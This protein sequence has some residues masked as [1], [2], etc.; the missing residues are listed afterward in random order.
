MGDH[1]RKHL[2]AG[3]G[4]EGLGDRDARIDA[5]IV[6]QRGSQRCDG[7][8]FVD[9]AYFDEI[10]ADRGEL[11]RVRETIRIGHGGI[12][13]GAKF[14]VER[15]RQ[16]FQRVSASPGLDL[17]QADHVGIQSGQRR[18]QFIGLARQF[19]RVISS[20]RGGV[21]V[22]EKKILK[23]IGVWGRDAGIYGGC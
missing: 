1:Q 16:G 12:S 7:S 2:A 11:L 8:R 14:G 21:F 15:R 4:A 13:P 18:D 3:V 6:H 10:A 23:R 19:L 17:G 9:Q 22:F 5:V 20:A